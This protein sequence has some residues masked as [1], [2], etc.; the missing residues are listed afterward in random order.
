M[1]NLDAIMQKKAGIMTGIINA[2]NANDNAALQEHMTSFMNMVQEQVCA[3]YDGLVDSHNNRVLAA[4]G[5]R[6]LTSDERTYWNAFI[7]AHKSPNFRNEIANIE[8]AFPETIIDTVMEDMK[9]AFPLLARMNLVNTSIVT[10]MIVN[11]KEV[12]MAQW[13]PINSEYVK[14]LSGSIKAIETTMCK[15]T[16]FICVPKDMIDMGPEWVD[17]YVRAILVEANGRALQHGFIAGTG[18]DMP[19]GM[20]KSIAPGVAVTDGEYPDKKAIVLDA[21]NPVTIGNILGDMAVHPETSRP[22][23][24]RDLVFLCNP[25]DNYKK[26]S[27]ATTML[28]DGKYVKNVWPEPI[29]TIP[30]EDVPVGKAILGD[31]SR[32]FGGV[33][34][35]KKGFIEYD[36]SVRFFE[37]QRVYATKTHGMGRAADDNAF[38]LLDISKLSSMTWLAAA[39]AET[40]AG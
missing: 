32:Y 37:D 21:I 24:L 14:E 27:P 6:M 23:T 12:Q 13:G 38:K 18:K 8:V 9:T 16:A 29:E 28:V 15:L 10:K 39:T 26:V 7:A 35:K 20:M 36:D 1:E 5:V 34:A 4:R 11:T 3:E 19:I 30:C 31:V 17:R 33:G 2:V 22:R 25:V 40:S